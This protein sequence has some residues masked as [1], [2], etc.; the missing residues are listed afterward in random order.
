MGLVLGH[1]K[2]MYVAVQKLKV[3]CWNQSHYLEVSQGAIFI[4]QIMRFGLILGQLA[5]LKK[6]WADYEQFLRPVFFMLSWAKEI[7]KDK[8][9]VASEQ[10]S[11][12]K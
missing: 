5:I 4:E 7:N 12:L 9:I 10:K 3:T 2:N 8:N 1:E 11:C 6:N